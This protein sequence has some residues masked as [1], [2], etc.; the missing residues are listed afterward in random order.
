[1]VN[2]YDL[3]GVQPA[4]TATAEFT[5]LSA[6]IRLP[7]DA[8]SWSNEWRQGGELAANVEKRIGQRLEQL[9][10]VH[11]LEMDALKR[12]HDLRLRTISGDTEKQSIRREKAKKR[13]KPR[14]DNRFGE[15]DSEQQESMDYKKRIEMQL[16]EEHF[17]LLWQIP[18]LYSE[19][20][21]GLEKK[22]L[23]NAIC[24]LRSEHLAKQYENLKSTSPD[25]M[26]S[27]DEVAC[28]PEAWQTRE[29]TLKSLWR[30]ED[31]E[32]MWRKNNESVE[33]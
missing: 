15:L 28:D 9:V 32:Q 10:A 21:N 18:Q 8:E 3:L 7:V 13:K 14:K 17:F 4:K 27:L 22:V 31:R 16:L 11:V 6:R 5:A 30:E 33:E 19:V 12:T 26:L 24:R 20:L 23:N 1:M 29:R 2:Y 25:M